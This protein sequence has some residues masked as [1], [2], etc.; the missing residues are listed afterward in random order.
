[1]NPG[2]TSKEAILQACRKIAAEQG[3]PALSMRAV[4][5]ECGI[6]L[7]TLYNYY[8]DKDE[9]LIAAVE[10]VWKDIFHLNGVCETAFSFPDYVSYLFACARRGTAE[11][12]NFLTAHS[13]LKSRRN[14]AK[15]TM[16][17]YFDH[18]KAGM[19]EVLRADP[20]VKQSA[21]S[22]CFTAANFVDFVLDNILLLLFRETA[23]CTTLVELVRRVIY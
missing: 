12:P 11:Y 8:S 16:D 3:L 4:A 22:H 13:M 7:G 9:L 14:E 2:A 5:K 10:S 18:M 21:F 1:M 17:R 15:S 23:S 19:L 20:A 6:A